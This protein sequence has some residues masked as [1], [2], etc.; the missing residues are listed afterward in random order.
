MSVYNGFA[1]QQVQKQYNNAL[2]NVIYLL[3]LKVLK[4]YTNERF[5]DELF[6]AYF[7]K[8]FAKVIKMDQYK[9]KPPY[10][11]ESMKDLFMHINNVLPKQS[12][13]AF[14]S[15]KTMSGK[16]SSSMQR[17]DSSSLRDH[18]SSTYFDDRASDQL[19]NLNISNN[20]GMRSES[21]H[22]RLTLAKSQKPN[23]SMLNQQDMIPPEDL[24]QDPGIKQS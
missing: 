19:N 15:S 8:L 13:P 20:F 16:P 3:Q 18:N 11:S 22:S 17:D 7:S 2:Y 1:K 10:Y 24:F 4:S 9:F 14:K 21:S 5:D 23:I 12:Q 6:K